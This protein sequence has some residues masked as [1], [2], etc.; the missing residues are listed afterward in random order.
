[1]LIPNVAAAVVEAEWSGVLRTVRAGALAIPSR[2]AQRLT[3]LSA[4]DISM[5]D[6]EAPDVL[7]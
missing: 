1:M 4:H 6:S 3:H 7:T 2:A 5:I